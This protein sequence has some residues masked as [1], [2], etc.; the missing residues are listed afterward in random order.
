[1]NRQS[2]T[3]RLVSWY[4]GLLFLL[5]VAFAGY[6]YFSF[7]RYIKEMTREELTSRADAIWALTRG[8]L[9]DRAQLATLIEQ[10]FA[11]ATYNRFIRV[12]LNGE[13]RYQSDQPSE[14][15]FNSADVPLQ[16]LDEPP[17]LKK[18][19]NLFFHVSHFVLP[20][21][22]IATVEVG[23]VD[24][25]TDAAENLLTV[26]LVVGVPVLLLLAAVSGVVLMQRALAPVESMIQAAEALTF[27]SP[28]NRLPL[29]GT[30][31]RIDALGRTLNRMLDRLDNAYQH[32]SRFSSD[33]AHELRTPLSIIR[34]ELEMLATERRLPPAVQAALGN[35]LD[36]TVR[37]AQ[38]VENLIALSRLDSIT[39]KRAHL[40]VDLCALATETIEQMR[41]LADEKSIAITGPAA[42]SG[43]AAAG[44][45]DRLKQV[46]VN[47]LDNAIK[48]TPP[49]GHVRVA[50]GAAGDVVALTVSDTG[51]G[52]ADEHVALIFDRFYRVSTDRGENGTGIGLA[53]VRSICTAHGGIVTVR[54]EPGMGSS[55]RVELPRA[56]LDLQGA[57]VAADR[58]SRQQ[59]PAL[60]E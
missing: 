10:H 54:S 41:L 11:P 42:T 13:I 56:A 30:G 52:I 2:L 15:G 9:D 32:A 58:G 25:L 40:P 5:G 51:I 48:Y 3:F 59:S 12:Q 44:D 8:A 39:G 27:N 17:Q 43:I 55:F 57:G 16:G 24:N 60:L 20:D 29:A 35:I 4:C 14:R 36:E 6:T 22:R 21:G 31:D 33:A 23:R 50:V 19:G 37:L 34:G 49:G 38:L 7:D 46:V 45:R 47:L 26:S 28:R 18:Y 53:I 1:V